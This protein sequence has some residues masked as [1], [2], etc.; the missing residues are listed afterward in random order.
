L[1]TYYFEP[2]QTRLQIEDGFSLWVVS[3]V[4]ARLEAQ[5]LRPENQVAVEF[6]WCLTHCLCKSLLHSLNAQIL[7]QQKLAP[8]AD[9]GKVCQTISWCITA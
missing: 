5:Q 2:H 8:A 7:L 3:E 6:Y 9:I 4:D 1:K